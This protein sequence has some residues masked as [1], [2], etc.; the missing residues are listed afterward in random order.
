M[1]GREREREGERSMSS[2]FPETSMCKPISILRTT[3]FPF[4]VKLVTVVFV[5]YCED[6]LVSIAKIQE[7]EGISNSIR[8]P[9]TLECLGSRAQAEEF[10]PDRRGPYPGSQ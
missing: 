3:G 7:G 5:T 4:I 8:S 9:N 2:V 10:A 6:S 1:A